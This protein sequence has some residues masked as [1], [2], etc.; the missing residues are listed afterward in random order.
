MSVDAQTPASDVCLVRPLV[1]EVAVSIVTLPVPVIMELA[2]GAF[3]FGESCR[4]APHV[5]V[6]VRRNRIVANSANTR[7]AFV[8]KSASELHFANAA[9][10]HECNRFTHGVAGTTLSSDLTHPAVLASGRDQSSA[11]VDIVANRLFDVSIFAG[12]HGPNA[13][14]CVPMVGCGRADHVDRAVVKRAT[15]VANWFRSQALLLFDIVAAAIGHSLIHVDDDSN[16]RPFV[17][18]ELADV[19]PT[20][21]VDSNNSNPQLFV[22]RNS[23]AADGRGC[24]KCCCGEG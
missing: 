18:Q 19:F 16:L 10:L 9:G 20:A 2:A 21:A 5:K 17:L 14:Q 24:H 11:F 6:D 4:A 7:A 1:A 8:A 13:G 12:L 23:R 15:H 3:W 22:G